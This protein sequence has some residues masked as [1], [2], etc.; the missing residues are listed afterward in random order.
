MK[1]SPPLPI[2]FDIDNNKMLPGLPPVI[3]LF[4]RLFLTQRHTGAKHETKLEPDARV[5][6]Q[7]NLDL[8]QK[9]ALIK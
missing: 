7:A 1:A 9:K 2:T 3:A 5:L 4:T 8:C 6:L